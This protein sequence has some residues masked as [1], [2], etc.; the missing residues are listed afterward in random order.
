MHRLNQRAFRILTEELKRIT[1]GPVDGVKRDIVL[2]R[3]AKLQLQAGTPL[4]YEEIKAEIQDIFP[5]FDDK[6][7][8]RAARANRGN[9]TLGKV[10]V[11]VVGTVAAVGGVWVLNLPYPMIR[12]PVAKVAPIVLMPSYVSMDHSYRQ[13][14]ALVEQADQLIN[15]ATSPADLDIGAEKATAAQKHLDRLPVWFLGYFPQTYCTWVQCSWRFTLDEFEAA[16]KLVGRIDATLFQEKN[17]LTLLEQGTAEVE[18][19][20]QQYQNADT[21]EAKTA[22]A[23]L[24]QRGMDKLN[25][26]P[27]ATLAGRMAQTKLDAYSRDFAQVSG[28]LAGDSRSNSLI[29]AAKGFAYNASLEAQ[30]PPHTADDWRRIVDLWREA[31]ARLE[32][33]PIEDVG[34]AE[35]QKMLVEYTTKLGVIE[36][37]LAAEERS[38]R[39]WESAEAKQIQL[40]GRADTMSPSAYASAAQSIISD[41]NRI[42]PNTTKYD[43]AQTWLKNIQA[44]L[45]KVQ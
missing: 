41:L 2:R 7:L 26:I 32:R 25:E 20:K 12:W 39:A 4:T 37:N 38:Q 6:V 28:L 29:E 33:I 17:A 18:Q 44:E 30:N 3:L 11:V 24:W 31:I 8:R 22:A 35:A 42:E 15:Q 10:K 40:L 34:Y 19:A 5:E 1:T 36:R 45:A 21:V 23:T 27:A 9:A 14:I 43:L 16:R 13:A